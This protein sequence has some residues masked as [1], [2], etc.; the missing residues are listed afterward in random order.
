MRG[1]AWDF[2]SLLENLTRSLDCEGSREARGVI[3]MRDRDFRLGLLV[4]LVLE[5]LS[6]FMFESQFRSLSVLGSMP[7]LCSFFLM[8]EFQKFLISLSVRLGSWVNHLYI[9]FTHQKYQHMKI[10]RALH[11]SQFNIVHAGIQQYKPLINTPQFQFIQFE[12]TTKLW[13]CCEFTRSYQEQHVAT[14]S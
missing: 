4:G 3:D 13:K 2:N 14:N 10:A 9:S 7:I 5:E 8:H 1:A 6:E 11:V 12:C